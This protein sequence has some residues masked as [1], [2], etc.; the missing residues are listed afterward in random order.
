MVDI[1]S[2]LNSHKVNK[3]YRKKFPRINKTTTRPC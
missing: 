1:K 3:K 2:N